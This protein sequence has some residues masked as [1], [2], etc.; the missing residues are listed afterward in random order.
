[1]IDKQGLVTELIRQNLGETKVGIIVK[2]IDGIDPESI[3]TALTSDGQRLYVSVIGYTEIS[4]RS[5]SSYYITNSIEK[6]VLWRSNP[7]CAG[8]IIV[9][10]K[11]ETDKLHSLSEFESIS[12]RD[13]TRFLIEK[14][15]RNDNNTPTKNFW[16]ALEKTSDYY[17]YNAVQ[18]FVSSVSDSTNPEDAIPK[19]MWR[20]NLLEDKDILGTKSKPENRL[21]QNRNMIFAIGQLSEES[22]KKLSRSLVR[23]KSGDKSRQQRAY[24]TLQSF[25]KYG[26][27]EALKNLDLATVQELF[28]ASQKTVKKK[29]KK[30]DPDTISDNSGENK[31]D[32]NIPIRPKELD[33]L[34]SD[35]VVLGNDEQQK[36][37]RDLF[38]EMDKH[39]ASETGG[40]DDTISPIGGIFGDRT[41]ALESH[42]T[43]L[44][45]L[46]GKFCGVNSWGG[47]METDESVLK[48]AISADVNAI[49][50]FDPENKKAIISFTGG[51][52]GNQPLFDFGYVTTNS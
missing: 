46:I 36:N 37:I 3:V 11:A 52:D 38:E 32:V 28:S 26:N 31:P 15:L 12:T 44:R 17:T 23:L 48:D 24:R 16:L 1:M 10:I 19:N 51:I 35:A 50:I 9:F 45:K 13:V 34:I 27:H 33:K 22:R 30:D 8:S 39:Y 20:L 43:D 21:A 25:Y 5:E 47:I 14:Q 4:E 18:D 6:A 29:R 2:G 42:Q 40:N 49:H 41:I 7:K